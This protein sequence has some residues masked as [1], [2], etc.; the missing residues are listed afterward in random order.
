MFLM[1]STNNL[2]GHDGG[3]QG[4]ATIMAF[5]PE[6][7]IGV[8]LFCNQGETDLEDTLK[9]TYNFGTKL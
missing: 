7:N 1:E 5:N 9:A 3:E 2:W 6:N 4:V 8:I